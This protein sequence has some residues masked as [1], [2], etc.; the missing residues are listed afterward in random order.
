MPACSATVEQSKW[1]DKDEEQS[2]LEKSD[3][4]ALPVPLSWTLCCRPWV[5][6][7]ALT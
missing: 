7:A 2:R 6:P 4:R 3:S 5:P 1:P